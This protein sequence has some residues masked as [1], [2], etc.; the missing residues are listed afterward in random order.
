MNDF[1]REERYVVFKI[2]DIVKYL[3]EV[4]REVISS[5]GDRLSL[6]RKADGKRP[7][8]SLVIES[9]WPE[10]ELAWAQIKARVVSE[11]TDRRNVAMLRAALVG[12]IGADSEHEL[13]QMAVAIQAP[14]APAHDKV[15][16]LNAI[17]ALLQS[18]P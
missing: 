14:F 4:D 3:H 5:I 18:M 1:A 10:Y 2:K 12:L 9:D 16:A 8:V 13:R 17:N 7:F 11:Q 15:V 6:L